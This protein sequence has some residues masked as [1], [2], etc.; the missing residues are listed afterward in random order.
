MWCGFR[1]GTA[2]SSHFPFFLLPIGTG[3]VLLLFSLQSSL[4]FGPREVVTVVTTNNMC[5]CEQTTHNF[6]LY[7]K[8][9]GGRGWPLVSSSVVHEWPIN[10]L[11]EKL[12]TLLMS[13]R[14][15]DLIRSLI[16]LLL[17]VTNELA[18]NMV[19]SGHIKPWA[20][21]KITSLRLTV[22]GGSNLKSMSKSH[23]A[24]R[25]PKP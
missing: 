18:K 9:G 6:K 5:L 14:H 16:K 11:L 25:S 17:L 22:L 4:L 24:T 2:G 3:S 1:S 8:G 12:C 13:L 19:I 23:K 20:H 7:R 10:Y 21:V 15:C